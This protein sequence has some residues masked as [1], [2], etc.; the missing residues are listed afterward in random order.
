MIGETKCVA[1]VLAVT[2]TRHTLPPQSTPSI[3]VAPPCATD[4]NAR[5]YIFTYSCPPP[6]HLQPLYNHRRRP[7]PAVANCGG[8]DC[9]V[10]AD[11]VVN[12][13]HKDPGQAALRI[14]I[15]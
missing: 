4:Q 10:G 14:E 3:P 15:V 9:F 5:I 8:A 12:E 1:V 2:V 11:E 6:A 13:G 7:T